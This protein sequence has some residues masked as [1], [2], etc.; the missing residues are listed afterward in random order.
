MTAQIDVPTQLRNTNGGWFNNVYL[1]LEKLVAF[2]N[3]L[4]L[5]AGV[6]GSMVIFQ[7]GGTAAPGIYTTFGGAF[8][9]LAAVR[10]P[11]LY[12]DDEFDL[13]TIPAG[14][15]VLPARMTFVSNGALVVLEDGAV[16]SPTGSMS[17]VALILDDILL[18]SVATTQANFQ[19]TTT[20]NE[21]VVYV[22]N[23][24]TLTTE[25]EVGTATVPMFSVAASNSLVLSVVDGSI[26][27]GVAGAPI[28]SV[29]SS[30]QAEALFSTAAAFS[31]HAF[32][33][34]GL[35]QV[36]L[37]DMSVTYSTLQP[38]A[39]D[40]S[41]EVGGGTVATHVAL[42][43]ASGQS[44]NSGV[45][46]TITG[47]AQGAGNINVSP[48]VGGSFNGSTGIF[49]APLPGLYDVTLKVGFNG[50]NTGSPFVVEVVIVYASGATTVEFLTF[51][52]V[53]ISG[54]SVTA[55]E[56]IAMLKGDTLTMT[57]VQ[58]SGAALTLINQPNVASTTVGI[59][60]QP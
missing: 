13:P 38:E 9:A 7:P 4:A 22:V 51:G 58:T 27:Q 42:V 55:S 29:A 57:A 32:A 60:Y 24:T 49:T 45:Q 37:C 54:G 28:V 11:I 3:A 12:I 43:N 5:G 52:L 14:Q 34:A 19:M 17:S 2:V 56:K 53:A 46:T 25:P 1:F 21:F 20:H 41:L 10:D 33:G 8:A 39:T 40:L 30:A 16:F 31:S 59:S 48:V 50:P 23:G 15:Y 6:L 18:G 26:V 36:L 35:I 47:W 44:F